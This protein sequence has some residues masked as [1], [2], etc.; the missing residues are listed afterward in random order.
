VV[1]LHEP[2][3]ERIGRILRENREAQG[4][5]RQQLSEKST[6]S[7]RQISAI[8]LGEKGPSMN[9]LELLL[10]SLGLPA[11]RVFYPELSED[12]PALS[13]ITHMAASCTEQQK[14]MV[15]GFIRMLQDEQYGD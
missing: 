5:T 10:R 12:D 8:E 11:D 1:E 6:I 15:I 9:S 13:Q 7:D 3:S 2:V 14:R 4:L